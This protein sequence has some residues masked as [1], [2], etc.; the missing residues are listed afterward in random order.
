MVPL[1]DEF[2][3]PEPVADSE[4]TVYIVVTVAF[5]PNAQSVPGSDVLLIMKDDDPVPDPINTLF[6]PYSDCSV[7]VPLPLEL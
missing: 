4:T 5:P 2:V 1:L 3:N 7:K 6:E